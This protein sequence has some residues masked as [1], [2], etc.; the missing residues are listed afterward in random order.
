MGEKK[1]W[2]LDGIDDEQLVAGLTFLDI[3]QKTTIDS[4][5]FAP[6]TSLPRR[7]EIDIVSFAYF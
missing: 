6:T 7:V 5:R 4:F 2:T 1:P 3:Y